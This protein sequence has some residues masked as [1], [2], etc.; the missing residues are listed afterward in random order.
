MLLRRCQPPTRPNTPKS[1]D[2]GGVSCTKRKKGSKGERPVGAVGDAG[3]VAEKKRK[4]KNA[5]SRGSPYADGNDIESSTGCNAFGGDSAVMP[6]AP[7][8]V[9]AAVIPAVMPAIV[10]A[11]TIPVLMAAVV[12]VLVVILAVIL[13]LMPAEI[14]PGSTVWR[15]TMYVVTMSLAPVV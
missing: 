10:L 12:P 4:R 6:T 14:T 13:A 2:G 15:E 1:T 8:M 9:V 5:L 7:A 3:G 11:M